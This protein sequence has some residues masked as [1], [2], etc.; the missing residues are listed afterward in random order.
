MKVAGLV[1]SDFEHAGSIYT[2]SSHVSSLNKNQVIV[3]LLGPSGMEVAV[4]ALTRGAGMLMLARTLK[5]L[6][7]KLLD[8]AFIREGVVDEP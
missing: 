7:L 3:R 2:I 6:G 8:E 5:S 4:R 1:T